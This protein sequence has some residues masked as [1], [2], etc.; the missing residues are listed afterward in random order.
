MRKLDYLIRLRAALGLGRSEFEELT[1][2]EMVQLSFATGEERVAER[3]RLAEAVNIA[4]ANALGGEEDLLSTYAQD[5]EG[6]VNEP[7]RLSPE[8]IVEHNRR[9]AEQLKAERNGR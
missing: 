9:A 6:L 4:I 5:L 3:Y 1:V 7:R 8:E 2:R